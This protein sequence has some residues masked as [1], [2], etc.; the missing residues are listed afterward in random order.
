[1]VLDVSEVPPMLTLLKVDNPVVSIPVLPPPP[2]PEASAPS[3]LPEVELYFKNLLL[4][5][6]VEISTSS[7]S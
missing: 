5:F 6:A 2:P 4:T 3:H 1:M 7:R